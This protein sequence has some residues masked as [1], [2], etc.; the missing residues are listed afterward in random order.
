MV[1]EPTDE[2][3]LERLAAGDTSAF[4]RLIDRHSGQV[5]SRASR[6]LAWRTDVDDVVQEV[7]L[8]LWTDHR[9]FRR[10]SSLKSW[11]ISITI[12]KCRRYHRKRAIWQKIV[13]RLARSEACLPTIDVSDESAIIQTAVRALPHKLR[14]IVVLRHLEEM[15]IDEIAKTLGVSRAAVDTRLH[16]A[17]KILGQTLKDIRP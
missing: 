14:E 15:P 11:L 5:F 16:R 9:K 13:G 12:L 7:F 17:R 3:L 4:D 2:C 8:T 6:L 10:E 1:D